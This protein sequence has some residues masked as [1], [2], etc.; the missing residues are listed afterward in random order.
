MSYQEPLMLCPTSYYADAEENYIPYYN[1]NK[2]E[3]CLNK[4]KVDNLNYKENKDV[5]DDSYYSDPAIN[6]DIKLRNTTIKYE[7]LLLDRKNWKIFFDA[8][9]K[10]TKIYKKEIERIKRVRNLELSK[11][12][13]GPH[14]HKFDKKLKKLIKTELLKMKNE[15]W[16]EF[17][18]GLELKE[19]LNQHEI[20]R[21][22]QLRR[23][24]LSKRYSR[25]TRERFIMKQSNVI[26][27]YQENIL[28]KEENK[29]LKRKLEVLEE[30]NKQLRIKINNR[31]RSKL[32]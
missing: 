12:Y 7:D 3:E 29:E 1:K 27:P 2:F 22:K 15:D 16:K 31:K 9:T 23:R 20:Q 17:I 24:E 6:N 30:E 32:N 14:I 25:D 26:S 4:I 13:R 10:D 28:I 5:D 21:L 18:K 8:L 19:I 11:K